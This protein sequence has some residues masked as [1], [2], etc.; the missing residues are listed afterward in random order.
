MGF[1]NLRPLIG[2]L[3]LVVAGFG[4]LAAEPPGAPSFAG[5]SQATGQALGGSAAA[6]DRFLGE[7]PR[8]ADA[9]GHAMAA[10]AIQRRLEAGDARG[11]LNAFGA[12]AGGV[13][14]QE[15]QAAGGPPVAAAA[16]MFQGWVAANELVRDGIF[17]PALV[18]GVYAPYAAARQAGESPAQAWAAVQHARGLV[19][20]LAE[21]KRRV[22]RPRLGLD[23]DTPDLSRARRTE[24]GRAGGKSVRVTWV[25][26][27]DWPYGRD[28][29]IRHGRE[30][31]VPRFSHTLD[32]TLT[33]DPRGHLDD[34]M[35]E[36]TR[37]NERYRQ[38]PG[39]L[40]NAGLAAVQAELGRLLTALA[41]PDS[42][43]EVARRIQAAA[44][45]YVRRMLEARYARTHLA[46]GIQ[47]TA[48]R[49][50]Q[51]LGAAAAAY[52]AWL[53]AQVPFTEPDHPPFI[54]LPCCRWWEVHE[55][56]ARR[57]K[58]WYLNPEGG[59][60]V[61]VSAPLARGFAPETGLFAGASGNG[62]HV[63]FSEI[64]IPPRGNRAIVV[65]LGTR[66][67]TVFDRWVQGWNCREIPGGL[68]CDWQLR[69]ESG[70]NVV[71]TG[72]VEMR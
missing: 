63:F 39:Y 58:G 52:Q 2:A 55:D 24:S 41:G 43:S 12:H 37:L 8:W 18:D 48:D 44:E 25:P 28:L 71:D 54:D 49:A 68:A 38:Y 66:P 42:D 62:Y 22:I 13:L 17:L 21:V 53:E 30:E 5:M 1:M 56:G 6:W 26:R 4:P 57:V 64:G 45:D 69:D 70:Q 9:L 23:P 29:L 67:E 33:G 50:R 14:L 11:A 35:Y 16:A 32:I 47:A 34:L 10:L 46:T 7:Q 15:W 61:Y 20:V 59:K 60:V 40:D 3:L 27:E 19:P 36:I 51:R 72:T 65:R 31:G